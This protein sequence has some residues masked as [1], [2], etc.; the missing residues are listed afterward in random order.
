MA[1][2]LRPFRR[3]AQ[4]PCRQFPCRGPRRD[5]GQD[6]PSRHPV[7]AV[8]ACVVAVRFPLRCDSDFP[9]RHGAVGPPQLARVTHLA[10]H[11]L[12]EGGTAIFSLTLEPCNA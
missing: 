6:V 9:R 5:W 8:Q 2:L 3:L 11:A 12:Q 7:S 4:E 1:V 10:G